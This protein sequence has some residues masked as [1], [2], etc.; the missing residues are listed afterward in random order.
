LRKRDPKMYCYNPTTRHDEDV[1]IPLNDARA[2]E[3]LTGHPD[4]EEFI[5]EYRRRR[6]THGIE[7]AMIIT[8]V[9]F[10][11]RTTGDNI[12]R[13]VRRGLNASQGMLQVDKR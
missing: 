9:A 6:K 3:M 12:L 11:R 2:I 4:S 8:G 1:P 13:P 7:K 5:E 10:F